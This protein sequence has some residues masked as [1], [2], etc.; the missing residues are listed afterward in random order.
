MPE[1]FNFGPNYLMQQLLRRVVE[2]LSEKLQNEIPPVAIFLDSAK[3]FDKI[4]CKVLIYK[5]I[6]LNF[7]ARPQYLLYPW[8]FSAQP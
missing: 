8:H 1:Q 2:F 5:V 4:F 3:T 6:P 7:E